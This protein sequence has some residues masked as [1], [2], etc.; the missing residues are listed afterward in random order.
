VTYGLSIVIPHLNQPFFLERCLKSLAPQ[1]SQ[2]P[3][4][5]VIVVD[6]GS[7]SPPSEIIA[8]FPFARLI[9]EPEPG[10]G[11]AR[12]KGIQVS[13]GE[14]LA[15]IDADCVAR[16]D[17]VKQ[18]MSA[19]ARHPHW[20]IAGGDVRIL[21][22]DASKPTMIEAYESIFAFRQ[23]EYIFKQHFSGT[24]NLAMRREAFE[25]VGPFAGIGIAEDRDWGHRAVKAGFTIHYTPG[26][27]VYHPAR[28]TFQELSQK[29]DRHIVHDFNEKARSVGGRLKW[30]GL[31]AVVVLSGLLD[32][33]KI[34]F[35]DR[36]NSFRERV[37]ASAM[38]LRIR[39]YRGWR[40]FGL[41]FHRGPSGPKWNT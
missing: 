9:G 16:N 20:L 22:E 25:V 18:L 29:W 12:N 1:L 10:P 17:W 39:L 40:M 6:N 32:I 35:S 31:L 26:M 24:G 5:E 3:G 7:K 14:L 36:V 4:A 27:I 21:V 8:K 28:K 34:A 33:R 15:F 30:V 23:K 19:F 37:L 11:P 13:K 2:Y 38:L 41:V